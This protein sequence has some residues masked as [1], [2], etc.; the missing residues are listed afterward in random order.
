MQLVYFSQGNTCLCVS[1]WCIYFWVFMECKN[2]IVAL[3]NNS[4]C[5]FFKLSK[6]SFLYKRAQW[7]YY[8]QNTSVFHSIY[9]H[10]IKM[11]KYYFIIFQFPFQY[12]KSINEFLNILWSNSDFC[13]CC[14][15]LGI[16]S[17]IWNRILYLLLDFSFLK[18]RL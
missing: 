9:L 1:M 8:S 18:N 14:K 10:F 17:L 5:M 15:P 2:I 7:N 12:V 11:L 16:F 6:I 3:Y 4:H 13:R